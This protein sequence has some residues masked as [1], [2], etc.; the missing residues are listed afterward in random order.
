[1]WHVTH[2]T[3]HPPNT[4]LP[5]THTPHPHIWGDV[6]KTSPMKGEVFFT[7]D[8]HSYIQTDIATLWLNR[9]SGPNQWKVLILTKLQSL[10]SSTRTDPS[11]SCF[12]VVIVNQINCLC[13]RCLG[14]WM[15]P[16]FMQMWF[17]SINKKSALFG[18]MCKH[19]LEIQ[20]FC[21]TCCLHSSC[22]GDK[23]YIS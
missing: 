9:P 5:H 7:G 17:D 4:P 12:W 13:W 14:F 15:E 19:Q 16:F 6:K 11:E 1:M 2:D 10:S 21:T 18:V 23:I 8:I 3:W 20:C 22:R